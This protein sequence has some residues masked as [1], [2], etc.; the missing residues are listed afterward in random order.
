MWRALSVAGCVHNVRKRCEDERY[1]SSNLDVS[2]N[3]FELCSFDVSVCV[4]W[5]NLM[6]DE[7]WKRREIRDETKTKKMER[8]AYG[9]STLLTPRT[10][11]VANRCSMD[12][13]TRN[14]QT[15]GA[16]LTITLSA[17]VGS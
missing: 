2:T 16:I 8:F 15:M 10:S 17:T 5:P 1:I 7:T 11:N 12:T 6:H 4:V 14:G 9:K 13:K 3:A